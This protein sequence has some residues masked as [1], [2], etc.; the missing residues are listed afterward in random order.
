MKSPYA[1]IRNTTPSSGRRP[2]RLWL[3]ATRLSVLAIGLLGLLSMVPQTASAEFL[4]G[5]AKSAGQVGEQRDGYL[6]LVDKR[7]PD[8]VKKM[9]AD[10]NER[11][12][13]R[14][15]KVAER[16]GTPIEQVGKQAAM[17]NFKH[18]QPGELIQAED[19]SWQKKP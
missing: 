18:A 17:R 2:Q 10:T 12:K 7:A 6:G 16:L 1:Q 8:A 13:Q 15:Q 11:R 3:H 19:G 5:N 14:Y 4:L 9:V